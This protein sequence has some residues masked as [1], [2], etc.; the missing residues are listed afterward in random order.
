MFDDRELF[1]QEVRHVLELKVLD[2]TQ[3]GVGSWSQRAHITC[4]SKPRSFQEATEGAK[5]QQW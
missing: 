3:K 5:V 2:L 4:G 1:L